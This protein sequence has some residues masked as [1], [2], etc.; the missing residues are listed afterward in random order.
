MKRLRLSIV[1]LLTIMGVVLWLLPFSLYC[2]TD[3][4]IIL[5]NIKGTTEEQYLKALNTTIDDDMTAYFTKNISGTKN[6]WYDAKGG[7]PDFFTIQAGTNGTDYKVTFKQSLYEPL[8]TEVKENVM[9]ILLDDINNSELSFSNRTR[10][11]NFIAESDVAVSSLVRQ[12]SEDVNADFYS[13]YEVFR[14]FSGVIGTILG[15]ICLAIFVLL[16]L[17]I[18][19]DL[20]YMTIPLWRSFADEHFAEGN[21]KP[22]TV[23]LEA[24]KAV[25]TVENDNEGRK[26]VVSI[27]FASKARQMVAISICVLYLCSGQIYSLIANIID[28]F[29]GILG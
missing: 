27:Y 19:C 18:A 10:L 9:R 26:E 6:S 21:K 4:I 5:E 23:S 12:L 16:S 22:K 8:D 20:C 7:V 15:T 13:G 17:T 28:Y 1:A 14:P 29:T 3:P 2:A 11:Y 24:Y 25:Q